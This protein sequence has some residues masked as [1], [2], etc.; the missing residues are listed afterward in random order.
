MLAADSSTLYQST[1]L[2]SA[3]EVC[4][5]LVGAHQQIGCAAAR[6]RLT[7]LH[8]HGEEIARLTV[9]LFPHLSADLCHGL[10]QRGAHRLVELIHLGGGELRTLME[11]PCGIRAAEVTRCPTT[12]RCRRSRATSSSG[13]YSIR[14]TPQSQSRRKISSG[15]GSAPGSFSTPAAPVTTKP[16]FSRTRREAMLCRAAW[17]TS[18][19]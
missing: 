13:S 3:A 8:V 10:D 4:N 16:H 18:G 1:R 12:R 6:A 9:D 17:A 19:L 11:P 7:G 2:A 14:A 15:T 5:S